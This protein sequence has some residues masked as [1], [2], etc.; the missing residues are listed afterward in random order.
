MLIAHRV[1]ID[2]RDA[3]DIERNASQRF[4]ADFIDVKS[5]TIGSTDHYMAIVAI[6]GERQLADLGP[7]ATFKVELQPT[8]K[9]T[10]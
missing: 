5:T 8:T 6:N 3:I 1:R 9:I 10:I 2:N 4:A 7:V